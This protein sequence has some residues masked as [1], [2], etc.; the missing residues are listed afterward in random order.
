[1]D[2]N[3]EE[4]LSLNITTS[5]PGGNHSSQGKNK[6]KKKKPKAYTLQTNST[7]SLSQGKRPR[8]APEAA[9]ERKQ[10]GNTSAKRLRPHPNGD[11]KAT[12]SAINGITRNAESHSSEN[13]PPVKIDSKP[14]KT[15]SATH[16]ETPSRKHPQRTAPQKVSIL[17][18]PS[19]SGKS[20]S[21]SATRQ[22]KADSYAR[23]FSAETFDQ[24]PLHKSLILQLTVGGPTRHK[25]TSHGEGQD[26]NHGSDDEK[27]SNQKGL[28][29]ERPTNA[30]VM[31][32]PHM[33]SGH[34]VLLKS[35]T[36]SG[37]TLT[38]LCPV[39]SDLLQNG[40]TQRMYAKREGTNTMVK[41]EDG[42]QAFIIAP[43]RELSLQTARVLS[44]LLR[45]FPWI[46]SGTIAGGE[47]RKS[48]K[49]R[50]R[51]GLNIVVATP[52]RLLDH[53]KSTESFDARFV[54]TIVFDEAD[55]L[56]DLGFE[57]QIRDILTV[58]SEHHERGPIGMNERNQKWQSVFCSA[59]LTE[60]VRT[61]AN[62][63][64]QDT[65][66]VFV[67]A[68]ERKHWTWHSKELLHDHST[69]DDLSNEHKVA[70]PKQLK[71]YYSIVPIKWR[72]PTLAAFLRYSM[73]KD[74]HCK[75]VV[76]VSSCAVVDFLYSILT[77]VWST[78]CAET[79]DDLSPLL[80]LHG[81]MDQNERTDTYNSFFSATKGLMIATDVAARGLDLPTVTWI[82]QLDPPTETSEYIHRVGRTARKGESGNALLFLAPHEQE[83]VNV[84]KEYKL[85]LEQFGSSVCLQSLAHLNPPIS[86]LDL[87]KTEND[88]G[89]ESNFNP[90]TGCQLKDNGV[91][92]R[93]LEEDVYVA[94]G[95]KSGT[96]SNKKHAVGTAGKKGA[97]RALEFAAVKWQ[98]FFEELVARDSNMYQRAVSA[99]QAFVRA[100]ATHSK[101]TKAIFHPRSLHLGHVAKAFGLKEQPTTVSKHAVKGSTKHG[102]R[103]D[104]TRNPVFQAKKVAAKSRKSGVSSALSEFAA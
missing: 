90:A 45:P 32:I 103:K 8:E 102:R 100:Y 84:L 63:V 99:F 29:F 56:L 92:R 67:D 47:K 4:E 94:A 18:G 24:L 68:D 10:V 33:V 27:K 41:R 86:E 74:P 14:T 31:A 13:A 88:H 89:K 25:E 37:K 91:L 75:T 46:V 12:Q 73:R 49:A 58:V 23:I 62:T 85:S 96:K 35:E 26:D 77:S 83:Y 2:P 34:D 57:K 30:Q 40:A 93:I 44:Q 51:K 81:D 17:N 11:N 54:R 79:E 9:S 53:L 16:S 69:V 6:K 87:E 28:G 72:L 76:F 70:T 1:M 20:Q 22:Q 42:P 52:G 21:N 15:T 66:A 59:T 55:R 95:V 61:L 97:E 104:A 50:L 36:G 101:Q 82:V 39:L 7:P 98:T 64:L 65:K 71:Q 48:E 80:R 43:T 60:A 5:G 3:E 78:L 19:S 38:F